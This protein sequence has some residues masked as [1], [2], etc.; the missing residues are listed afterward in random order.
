MPEKPGGDIAEEGDDRDDMEQ[1]EP[2][3]HADSS[4]TFTEF[5]AAG[6]PETSGLLLVAIATE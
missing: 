5:R 6:P 3:I 2:E 4:G 1:L